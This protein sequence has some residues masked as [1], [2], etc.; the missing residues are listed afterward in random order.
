[1][2][3]YLMMAVAFY[4]CLRDLFYSSYNK[5]LKCLIKMNETIKNKMPSFYFL[6]NTLSNI[7]AL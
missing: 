2:G 6:Q 3:L 7:R 1:M 5:V 4:I